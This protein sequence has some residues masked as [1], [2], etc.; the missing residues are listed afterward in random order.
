MPN[1]RKGTAMSERGDVVDSLV[2]ERYGSQWVL[3]ERERRAAAR[4]LLATL[5]ENTRAELEKSA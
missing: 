2:A 3:R 1:A 4:K 5:D